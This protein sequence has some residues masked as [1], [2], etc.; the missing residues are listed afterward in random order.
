MEQLSAAV[1]SNHDAANYLTSQILNDLLEQTPSKN[2]ERITVLNGLSG[3][4]QSNHQQTGR[5]ARE[6]EFR[7]LGC[8]GPRRG[9]AASVA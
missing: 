6:V 7:F 5:A 4:D 3:S 1:G 8:G 9:R 2:V